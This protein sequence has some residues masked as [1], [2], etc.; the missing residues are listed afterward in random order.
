MS[1]ASVQK[2]SDMT[3]TIT[4]DDGISGC[5]SDAVAGG[6]QPFDSYEELAGLMADWP[7]ARLVQV[8]NR[9][10]GIQRVER[11]TDRKTGILRILESERARAK[12]WKI[13]TIDNS[14]HELMIDRPQELAEFLLEYAPTE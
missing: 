6:A 5:S 10:P 9:L 12:G 7:M 13:R 8:W 2:G 4:S 3:F 1:S 14:G 11:F